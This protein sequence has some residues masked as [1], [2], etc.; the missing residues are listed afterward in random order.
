MIIAARCPTGATEGLKDFFCDSLAIADNVREKDQ[1]DEVLDN[2]ARVSISFVREIVPSL[3]VQE[4]S[5]VTEWVVR[6]DKQHLP[7]NIMLLRLPSTYEAP[8]AAKT[9]SPS[10]SSEATT[11]PRNIKSRKAAEV[12]DVEMKP[13]ED[14]SPEDRRI[15]DKYD[16]TL[17]PDHRGSY[18]DHQEAKL[19][20]GN[21]KDEDGM[22]IVP[23][24]RY[25]ELTEGTPSIAPVP[26]ETSALKKDYPSKVHFS[27]LLHII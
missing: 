18:F 23:H 13:S 25:E 26:L 22:P 9:A 19:V 20:Q 2:E 11:K 6:P 27:C 5:T 17:L 15:D 3:E 14:K 4:F 21:I 12:P 1:S 7:G 16:P 8:A 24:E 10:K